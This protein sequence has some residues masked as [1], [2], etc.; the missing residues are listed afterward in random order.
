MSNAQLEAAIGDLRETLN[1]VYNEQE[2]L[3]EKVRELRIR[4]GL[5]VAEKPG[6]SPKSDT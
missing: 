5:E 4:A 3:K 6:S 2:E 1:G